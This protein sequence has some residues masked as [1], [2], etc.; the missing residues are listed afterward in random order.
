M[1]SNAATILG[2]LVDRIVEATQLYDA[3][4]ALG[5]P[6]AVE[7][8]STAGY[9]ARD[10]F[11]AACAAMDAELRAARA[12]IAEMEARA[13]TFDDTRA[14]PAADLRTLVDAFGQAERNTVGILGSIAT[15]DAE[16]CRIFSARDAA[17]SALLAAIDN[18]NAGG[19]WVAKA[20]GPE[21][22]T[23][24]Q[25]AAEDALR[26]IATAMLAALG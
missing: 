5:T 9:A 8:A 11:D 2:A 14:A 16:A 22:G 26:G 4:V 7:A 10:A 6:S 24:G 20:S 19:G 17:K 23:A 3:Q 18:P 21:T 12:R 13:A 1:A 25:L 15:T